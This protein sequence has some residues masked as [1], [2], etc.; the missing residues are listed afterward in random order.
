MSYTAYGWWGKFKTTVFSFYILRIE[1]LLDF[2]QLLYSKNTFSSPPKQNS[3]F[4]NNYRI[5]LAF[6]NSTFLKILPFQV[7]KYV[8]KF[9]AGN[10]RNASCCYSKFKS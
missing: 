5:I 7:H 10:K 8:F 1:M 4:I 6:K 2:W 9:I 3:V